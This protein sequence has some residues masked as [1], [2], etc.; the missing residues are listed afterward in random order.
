MA[1]VGHR[2]FIHSIA[3][4]GREQSE[5]GHAIAFHEASEI[6]RGGEGWESGGYLVRLER[7]GKEVLFKAAHVRPSEL[8]E[9]VLLSYRLKES[10]C[11]QKEDPTVDPPAVRRQNL[12]MHDSLV[13]INFPHQRTYEVPLPLPHAELTGAMILGLIDKARDPQT[14]EES[15]WT[16]GPWLA[17]AFFV[18]DAL[19]I[20]DL[21]DPPVKFASNQEVVTD[22]IESKQHPGMALQCHPTKVV[23]SRPAHRRITLEYN[24]ATRTLGSFGFDRTKH[25]LQ[26]YSSKCVPDDGDTLSRSPLLTGPEGRAD[27]VMPGTHSIARPKSL[28]IAGAV[29][30]APPLDQ[31]EDAFADRFEELPDGASSASNATLL[32]LRLPTPGTPAAADEAKAVEAETVDRTQAEAQL[33]VRSLAVARERR[34]LLMLR[35]Q[36]S[37]GQNLISATFADGS[38][39]LRGK[40]RDGLKGALKKATAEVEALCKLSPAEAYE[41]RFQ[42]QLAS[43]IE[44]LTEAHRKTLSGLLDDVA[45]RCG[46]HEKWGPLFDVESMRSSLAAVA[47][48]KLHL[49]AGHTVLLAVPPETIPPEIVRKKETAKT[50]GD[51]A[52]AHLALLLHMENMDRTGVYEYPFMRPQ[53]RSEAVQA[54]GCALFARIFPQQAG[55][56][57]AV[58]A[59]S[60]LPCDQ[61]RDDE[62]QT[63]HFFTEADGRCRVVLIGDAQ[64]TE[65]HAVHTGRGEGALHGLAPQR[66]LRLQQDPHERWKMSIE[67]G[68]YLSYEVI[69][70]HHEI[71]MVQKG[72]L[73]SS[74]VTDDLAAAHEVWSGPEKMMLWPDATRKPGMLE[75]FVELASKEQSMLFCRLNFGLRH[76]LRAHATC[77]AT[78]IL[79]DPELIEAVIRVGTHHQEGVVPFM[80][81]PALDAQDAALEEAFWQAVETGAA[82]LTGP[83]KLLALLTS[84]EDEDVAALV[85]CVTTVAEGVAAEE[86]D[87]GAVELEAKHFCADIMQWLRDPKVLE[88]Q[89]LRAE[90]IRVEWENAAVAK[91]SRPPRKRGKAP[92]A[93]ASADE[94]SASTAEESSEDAQVRRARFRRAIDLI[95]RTAKKVNGWREKRKGINVLQ[96]FGLL[97]TSSDGVHCTMRGSHM[98]MHGEGG[99]TTVVRDHAGTKG[100]SKPVFLRKMRSLAGL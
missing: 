11:S 100:L 47:A 71:R 32:A 8:G 25:A 23:M 79:D 60:G 83:Q 31:A 39:H 77:E 1:L 29:E 48:G 40:A 90:Q 43:C 89:R 62:Q 28:Q 68:A 26:L 44:G 37:L 69:Y 67:E 57:E 91:G 56:G 84:A 92:V 16:I 55:T 41:A 88:E 61:R 75:W 96:K 4:L 30:P 18:F 3:D 66:S 81:A 97:S 9:M 49:W 52:F 70:P 87:A 53:A 95:D 7:S 12:Q 80:L 99:P 21:D 59:L 63:L 64:M 2:V 82:Q 5:Y 98:V 15:G 17:A 34:D 20:V 13:A 86:A 19:A 51:A 46:W 76:P 10:I 93:A 72:K 94:A 85:E 73:A 14:A 45:K 54:F 38:N 78:A 22:F 58:T 6:R 35:T 36:S 65:Q 42:A 74:T 33:C 50:R 27:A 24:D